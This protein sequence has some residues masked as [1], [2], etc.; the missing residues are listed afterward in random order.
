MVVAPVRIPFSADYGFRLLFALFLAGK[1]TKKLLKICALNLLIF[2][3]EMMCKSDG[4][5]ADLLGIP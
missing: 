3:T 2:R 4:K 5:L 1:R